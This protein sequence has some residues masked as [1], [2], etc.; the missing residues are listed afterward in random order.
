MSQHF[1]I[2][3]ENNHKEN[4]IAHQANTIAAGWEAHM[5]AKG[6]GE[7][8]RPNPMMQAMTRANARKVRRAPPSARR[9][10]PAAEP[11]RPR[12]RCGT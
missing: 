8:E 6:D 1:T 10:R 2:D 11:S 12:R 3:A 9:A 4:R 7:T 5:F